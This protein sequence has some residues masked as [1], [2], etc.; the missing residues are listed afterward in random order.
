VPFPLNARR[1]QGNECNLHAKFSAHVGKSL[2]RL[3]KQ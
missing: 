1:D 3:L 2:R